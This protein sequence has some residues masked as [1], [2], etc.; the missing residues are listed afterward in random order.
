MGNMSRLEHEID[1]LSAPSENGLRTSQN[2]SEDP[3]AELGNTA[4][5]PEAS[6]PRRPA[7]YVLRAGRALNSV[8]EAGRSFRGSLYYFN[9]PPLGRRRGRAD[10]NSVRR[11]EEGVDG[12]E[13]DGAEGYLLF[14]RSREREVD[15]DDGADLPS[16]AARQ[17]LTMEEWSRR[18]LYN[19]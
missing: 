6:D 13:A 2:P 17:G 10:E 14:D 1:A 4:V 19:G 18:N 7:Y 11:G 3:T 9:L 15:M 16:A 5:D 12:P 8:R